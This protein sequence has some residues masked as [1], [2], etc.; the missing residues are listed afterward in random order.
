M[1]T[2][3]RRPV[4]IAHIAPYPF[5]KL[6]PAGAVLLDVDVTPLYDADHDVVAPHGIFGQSFDGDNLAVDGAT[7]KVVDGESEMTTK[8]QGEGAIEGHLSDYRMADRFTT[9]FKYA[10]FDVA[11]AKPRDVT[12]LTGAKRTREAVPAGGA[13]QAS[14]SSVSAVEEGAE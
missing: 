7:D 11:A 1:R 9:A 10:R 3:V 2:L 13:K 8:A 5:A 4:L 12:K 14:V 6:N